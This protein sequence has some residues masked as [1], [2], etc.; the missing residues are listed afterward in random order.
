MIAYIPNTLSL[1]R[2]LLFPLFVYCYHHQSFNLALIVLVFSMLSD[3]FDGYLAR[4]YNVCSDLGALLDPIADKAF[5]C[6]YYGFLYMNHF[7]PWWLALIVLI[8]NFSQL[9]SVPIL[10]WWLKRLFKVKPKRL[11]KYITAITFMYILIP[12]YAP[13][14][15]LNSMY[16]LWILILVVAGEIKI[17]ID[18]IPRLLQI[19][20]KKH[21]TFE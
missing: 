5:A 4:K 15:F 20:L 7:I 3:F 17:L 8:R 14:S 6:C 16:H 21:D 13:E 9:M 19:A 2:V 10:S 1:S 12:L 11:P 18:Y